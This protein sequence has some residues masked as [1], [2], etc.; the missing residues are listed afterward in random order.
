MLRFEVS[1]TG[2]GI[3]TRAARARLFQPFSQADATTTRRYGGTGLGLCIAKQLVELMGGD[4]RRR[5]RAGRGQHVLLHAP[6]PPPGRAGR[7]TRSTSDLTGTVCSSC[8]DN[9]P[10]RQSLERQLAAWGINPDSAPTAA[11]RSELLDRA[12]D[13]GSRSK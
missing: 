3:D 9:A 5:E 1:D 11:P 7:P 4:D 2:I 13:A 12:A 8:D 10:G 6:L